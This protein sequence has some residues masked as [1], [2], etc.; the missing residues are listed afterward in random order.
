MILTPEAEQVV[1]TYQKLVEENKIVP[2][3]FFAP[4]DPY[5][6]TLKFSGHVHAF[7]YTLIENETRKAKD[8]IAKDIEEKMRSQLNAL[9]TDLEPAIRRFLVLVENNLAGSLFNSKF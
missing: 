8:Q 2:F 5:W 3:A 9:V 6:I 7:E 1:K 4:D